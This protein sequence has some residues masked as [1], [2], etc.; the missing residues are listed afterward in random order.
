MAHRRLR[1]APP[2]VHAGHRDRRAA[3]RQQGAGLTFA[4]GD[5]TNLAGLPTASVA[6]LSCLH[7]IEHVGLGRYGDAIDP[8]GWSKALREL[9][10]VLQAGGRL[11]LSVPIGAERLVF[12]A[13]RYFSPRTILDAL[14]ELRLQRFDAVDDAGDL[15]VDA[16]LDGFDAARDS[17]GIF[18]LTKA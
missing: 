15:R 5:L 13:H 10:R 16:P 1:R 8:D 18:E 4:R 7:T 17:C 14:P 3:A 6:S 11:Y 12:N 9:V 2:D